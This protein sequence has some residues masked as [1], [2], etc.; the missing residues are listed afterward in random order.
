MRSRLIRTS[1]AGLESNSLALLAMEQAIGS[2]LIVRFA[3]LG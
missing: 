2:A 1:D 3:L